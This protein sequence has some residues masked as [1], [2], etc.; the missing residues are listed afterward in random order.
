MRKLR[1]G[2]FRQLTQ[3]P[4]QSGPGLLWSVLSCRLGGFLMS[5]HLWQSE[6]VSLGYSWARTQLCSLAIGRPHLAW[7]SSSGDRLAWGQLGLPP[8]GWKVQG[9]LPSLCPAQIGLLVPTSWPCHHGLGW[10]ME[11]TWSGSCPLEWVSSDLCEQGCGGHQ[12][13]GQLFIS[14]LMA[15]LLKCNYVLRICEIIWLSFGE[16]GHSCYLYGLPNR[17]LDLSCHL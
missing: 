9:L 14:H 13:C 10:P 12:S 6:P 15:I 17:N 11:L 3:A 4:G 5:H 7:F 1:C 8:G 16:L 2:A